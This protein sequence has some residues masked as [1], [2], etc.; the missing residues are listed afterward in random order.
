MF[1]C[2]NH[3]VVVPAG[4]IQPQL[5]EFQFEISQMACIIIRFLGWWVQFYLTPYKVLEALGWIFI[6]PTRLKKH[7][8]KC[9]LSQN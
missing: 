9:F 7:L 3:I 2:G 8:D 6:S 1:P 4:V 5:I